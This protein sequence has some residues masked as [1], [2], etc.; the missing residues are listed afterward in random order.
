MGQAA[1]DDLRIDGLVSAG[2]SVVLAL[3]PFFCV[4]TSGYA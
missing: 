2:F 1:R 4:I 3:E